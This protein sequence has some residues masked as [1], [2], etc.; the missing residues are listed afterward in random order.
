LRCGV[1][2]MDAVSTLMGAEGLSSALTSG[3]IEVSLVA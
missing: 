1:M 2:V 3:D